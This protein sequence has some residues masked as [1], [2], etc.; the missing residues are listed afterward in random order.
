MFSKH[1]ISLF[2]K[3]FYFNKTKQPP[4]EHIQLYKTYSL[5]QSKHL[6]SAVLGAFSWRLS[7]TGN[8]SWRFCSFSCG[9]ILFFFIFMKTKRKLSRVF[10]KADQPFSNLLTKLLKG[11]SAFYKHSSYFYKRF[12][13]RLQKGGVRIRL[14][15]ICDNLLKGRSVPDGA[16]SL[17]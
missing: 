16:D 8:D 1:F 15:V 10:K 3:L 9:K 12:F 11:G 13:V 2:F 4:N 14:L 7:P 5:A 17:L 6:M